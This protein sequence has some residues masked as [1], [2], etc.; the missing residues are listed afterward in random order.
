MDYVKVLSDYIAIDNS[1]PPGKNY[2]A[3]IE[4]LEPLFR[5]AGFDTTVIGI[6]PEHAGGLEG[7]VNLI[8]HRR[9][10]GKP[11][12]VF[13]AHTDVVP[14]QGWDAFKP[15]F[16]NGRIYGRGAADMKG[17]A[18]GLLGALE[19][20]AHVA[21][22]YDVSVIVTT[23]EEVSQSDQL[24]YLARFLQPLKG[25]YVFS[26]DSSFG[27]VSVAGLGALHMDI[28][29]K[30]KSVH[31][32][33]SHLGKNAVEDAVLLVNAL[34]TLK[35]KVEARQSA[36]L[37]SPDTGLERMVSRLNVN[38]IEGGLKVNIVPERCVVSVDRRLIP[39][40]DMD[41]AEREIRECL[42]SVPGVDWEI[43][44]TFKIPGTRPCEDPIVD[45]LSEII[46]Q[47]TG[48]TGKFGEM[49]SGDLS[50]IVVNDWKGQSFGLGVIRPECNIHGKDEFV[51]LADIEA[52]GEI[53]A[54]FLVA[55]SP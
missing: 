16:E 9:A 42:A 51:Y 53:I 46:M 4:Y 27:F 31:S 19:K 1:V 3:A 37:V 32:A 12:L 38:K 34:L 21:L 44:K 24:R 50:H 22:A 26:L 28:V 55:G 40:E 14:A 30:G 35:K 6:P 54:R 25:A 33:M 43:A 41:D 23:D 13:Y 18:V 36:V 15:R 47:V 29:V 52:L 17:G 5:Q 39:E 48:Q 8:A 7:R 11:K 2:R 45:R 49:G 10:K 20:V